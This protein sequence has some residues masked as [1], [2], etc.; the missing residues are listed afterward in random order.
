MNDSRMDK[1]E[2]KALKTRTSKN[3]DLYYLQQIYNYERSFKSSDC[4]KTIKPYFANEI[5]KLALYIKNQN[6]I[7]DIYEDYFK[8]C[9]YLA[10]GFKY[11]PLSDAGKKDIVEVEG[12][13]DLKERFKGY[14]HCAT[15]Q[16]LP[17]EDFNV[18]TLE[19]VRD[20]QYERY[21]KR[22]AAEANGTVDKNEQ[23][24]RFNVEDYV[25]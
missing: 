21:L 3:K 23:T 17:W 1:Y 4:Y 11:Y 13:A 10:E 2:D 20:K 8:A 19:E 16:Y 18:P 9:A 24:M 6:T 14:L 25:E 12:L 15:L 5:E 7:L 22:K